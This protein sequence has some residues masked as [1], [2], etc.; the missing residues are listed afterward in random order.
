MLL[1]S[2]SRERLKP[3]RI[4]GS[5]VTDRPLFHSGSYRVGDGRVQRSALLYGPLQRLVHI[6][7]KRIPHRFIIK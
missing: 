6:L 2:H 7:R 5:A 3:V 4:V 1:G